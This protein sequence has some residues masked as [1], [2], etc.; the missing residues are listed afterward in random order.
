MIATAEQPIETRRA[1]RWELAGLGIAPFACTGMT[2][3]VHDM[4]GGHSKAGGTCDYCGQGIRYVFHIRS[5]DAKR[6]N[7]GCDCVAHT[8]DAAEVIVTQTKRMLKDHMRKKR[9]TKRA[10]SL[11][12]RREQR[13]AQIAAEIEANKAAL[14]DN[15]LYQRIVAIVGMANFAGAE[16]HAGNTFLQSMRDAFERWGGLSEAQTAAVERIVDRIE[17]EPARKAASQHVGEIGKRVTISGTVEFSKCIHYKE[18][19]GDTERHIN[20]IRTDDGHVLTWFGAYGFQQGTTLKGTASVKAHDE[21][22]GEKQTLIRNPR[23]KD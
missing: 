18:W 10:E 14:V 3:V 17:S 16:G 12:V 23:W 19:Y 13:A 2:E 22:Q 5:S 1:H 7:V 9:A 11:K 4:G 8:H 15:P 21:Y 20:K 6:F